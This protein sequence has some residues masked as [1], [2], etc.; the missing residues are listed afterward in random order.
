MRGLIVT[1]TDTNVGKTYVTSRIAR[2]LRS[3]KKKIG[4]CKPVCSGAELVVKD[5][6][7]SIVWED[8]EEHFDALGEEFPRELICPHC[9]NDPVSPSLA[10][11][12]SGVS[13]ELRDLTEAVFAWEE[14][15]KLLLI[16]GVGGFLCPLTETEN[17]A[18]FAQALGFPVLVVAHTGLGTLNHTLLTIEAIRQRG[19]SPVGIVLNQVT[20]SEGSLAEETN[21]DELSRWTDVPILAQIG[22]GKTLRLRPL[23]GTPT[24]EWSS[25]FGDSA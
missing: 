2:S 11:R 8:I 15:V 21:A 13:L 12:L 7:P 25:L 19:L 14:K 24:M 16:E 1:G 9:F 18:D 3:K 5:L 22:H 6:L 20:P 10:A 4:I 23:Q 17:F